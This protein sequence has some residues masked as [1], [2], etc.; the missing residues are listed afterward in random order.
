MQKAYRA[1]AAMAVGGVGAGLRRG[2]VGW[3]RAI[4]SEGDG[5]YGGGAVSDGDCD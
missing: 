2:A 3:R 1:P 4:G 5:E